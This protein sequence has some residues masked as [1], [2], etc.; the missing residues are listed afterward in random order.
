MYCRSNDI[1]LYVQGTTTLFTVDPK[2]FVFC[3]FKDLQLYVLEVQKLA[4]L[5]IVGPKTCFFIYGRT[6]YLQLYVLCVQ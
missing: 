2:I 4:T 3:A 6:K 5:C 1:K